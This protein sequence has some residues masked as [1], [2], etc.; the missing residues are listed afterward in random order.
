MPLNPRPSPRPSPSPNPSPNPSPTPDL[1]PTPDPTPNQVHVLRARPDLADLATLLRTATGPAGEAIASAGRRRLCQLMHLPHL[2]R[3]VRRVL[4]GY[5]LHPNPNPNPS[6]NPSPSPSPNP[7]PGT[8]RYS[9]ARTPRGCTTR[10]AGS[11]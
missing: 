7:N 6:P 8:P 9:R 5:A 4:G 10:Y 3:F 2:A 1:N 11:P